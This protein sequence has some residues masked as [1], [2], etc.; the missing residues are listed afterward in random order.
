MDTAYLQRDQT[1]RCASEGCSLPS[2]W[3]CPT[4]QQYWCFEHGGLGFFQRATCPGIDAHYPV[5]VPMDDCSHALLYSKHDY[6]SVQ[7]VI[8]CPPCGLRL[9]LP[10]IPNLLADPKDWSPQIERTFGRAW[11]DRQEGKQGARR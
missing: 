5:K 3:R 6:P 9:E 7:I 4:C 8:W 10:M 11:L 1:G 2:M